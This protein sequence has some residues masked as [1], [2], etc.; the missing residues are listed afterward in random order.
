MNFRTY[1]ADS[2]NKV[3]VSSSYSWTFLLHILN[4]CI[5]LVLLL[6]SNLTNGLR[7]H[8]FLMSKTTEANKSLKLMQM[9]LISKITNEKKD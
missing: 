8:Q 3:C 5:S 1:L 9:E 4:I 2:A 7:L 6:I